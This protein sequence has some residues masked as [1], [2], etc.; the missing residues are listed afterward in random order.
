MEIIIRNGEVISQ[1]KW[2]AI[3]QTIIQKRFHRHKRLIIFLE[4]HKIN[5]MWG[6]PHFQPE[7]GTGTRNLVCTY[8]ENQVCNT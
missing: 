5:H 2:G 3:I 6:A 1:K 4:H 8:V 7:P